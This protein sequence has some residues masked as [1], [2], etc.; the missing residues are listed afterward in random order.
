MAVAQVCFYSSSITTV[1]YSSLTD[2]RFAYTRT[3]LHSNLTSKWMGKMNCYSFSGKALSNSRRFGSDFCLE[4]L[5]HA[6]AV[7][8]EAVMKS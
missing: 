1:S 5:S 2:V 6:E 8:A 4:Q 7:N 3:F